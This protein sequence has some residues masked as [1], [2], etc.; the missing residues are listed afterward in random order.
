MII[1]IIMMMMM[2]MMM[3][4]ITS[5]K[6]A[7]WV[8]KC[9]EYQIYWVLISSSWICRGFVLDLVDIDLDLSY[10]VSDLSDQIFVRYRIVRYRFRPFRYRY[11][12]LPSKHCFFFTHSLALK[13]VCDM[14]RTHRHLRLLNYCHLK[15]L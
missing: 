14:I 6:I 2:M 8:W 5:T 4:M 12:F 10:T 15:E 3:V 13:R 1:I 9:D 11:R 7:I